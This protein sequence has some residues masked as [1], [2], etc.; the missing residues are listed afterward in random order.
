MFGQFSNTAPINYLI[1]DNNYLAAAAQTLAMSNYLTVRVSLPPM[2][3][4][5]TY[6]NLGCHE[7][8]IFHS[9]HQHSRSRDALQAGQTLIRIPRR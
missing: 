2:A 5:L 4:D 6:V 8:R 9:R 7:P 3:W 1:I